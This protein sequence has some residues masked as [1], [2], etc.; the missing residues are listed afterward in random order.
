MEDYSFMDIKAVQAQV[1]KK[2]EEQSAQ[3]HADLQAITDNANA[4]PDEVNELFA[5]SILSEREDNEKLKAKEMEAEKAKAIKEV[6]VKYENQGIKS[7][8]TKQLDDA[9]KDI[10]KNIPGMND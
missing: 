10:L 6:E 2:N 4:E 1:D 9:Y 5:K 8:A 3:F 7:D